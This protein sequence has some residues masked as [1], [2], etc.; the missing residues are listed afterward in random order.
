MIACRRGFLP[1][2]K[3][4][5]S[6]V[7]SKVLKKCLILQREGHLR[8]Y[9]GPKVLKIFHGPFFARQLP[10]PRRTAY[11]MSLTSLWRCCPVCLAHRAARRPSAS[12][13]AP[14]PP[15]RYLPRRCPVTGA[16]W[17]NLICKLSSVWIVVRGHIGGEGSQPRPCPENPTG[18]QHGYC[19]MVRLHGRG[20]QP[21]SEK[22]FHAVVYRLAQGLSGVERL[23]S[24]K[25]YHSAGQVALQQREGNL[26]PS[27]ACRKATE[28]LDHASLNL[29]QVCPIS[30][31]L[32]ALSPPSALS[33]WGK[34]GC[35]LSGWALSSKGGALS[36]W[37]RSFVDASR[38]TSV[39]GC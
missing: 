11:S 21:G 27:L 33:S 10:Y 39:M 18:R 13:S 17:P 16:S 12:I 4:K 19:P 34:L 3:Q 5:F 22:I 32:P 38:Q 8:K 29:S 31:A 35:H 24:Q 30:S 25:M 14:H 9:V 26:S 1:T 28:V 37:G 20:C 15:R 36:S 23:S 7:F 6:N 2:K